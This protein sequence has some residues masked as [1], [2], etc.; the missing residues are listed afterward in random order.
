[1]SPLPEAGRLP[2]TLEPRVRLVD[3]DPEVL[4]QLLALALRD[5]EPD[6]VTPP[7]G[8]AEGWNAARL[9]WFG[10]YHRAAAAGLDGPAREKSWAVLVAGGVAGSVRLKRAG[11]DTAETGIWLG[12]GFRGRGIGSAAIPLALTEARTAGLLRVVANTTQRNRGAQRILAACGARLTFDGDAVAAVVVLD[13]VDK[14]GA[15][16]EAEHVPRAGG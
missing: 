8:S 7:L 16:P 9:A 2:G 10:A 11:P 12:R 6:E 14:S 3:V 15:A 13:P 4:E 1:M 5:A